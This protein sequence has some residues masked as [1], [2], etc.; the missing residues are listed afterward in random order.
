MGHPRAGGAGGRGR[1][2]GAPRGRRAARARARRRARPR[3]RAAGRA[4]RRDRP[5]DHRRE[6]QAD[7]VGPRRG[8]PGGLRRSAGPPRRPA[9]SPAR[10]QRLDTDPAATG[11][12]ALVTPRAARARCWASRR[13]TS[14]STWCA[15][16]VAPAIAVGAPIMLKPAPATPLSALVL[17]EILAET[18]PARP[19]CSR[20]CRSRTSARPRWSRTRACR[21]S[22]SPAPARSAAR[23]GDAVPRKHVT[24]ELGGNAAAVVCARLVDRGRPRLGRH[25]DRHLL[26]LPGR[27]DLHRRPAGDRGRVASTTGWPSWSSAKVEALV[28]GDPTDE[29][30][31]V[32]PLVSEDA[33][34]RVETWVRRGASP[35]GAKL[36]D[37][38]HARRRHRT[39]RPCST[40]VP[41]RRQ[42]LPRGGLR[43]GARRCPRS[44]RTPRRFAAVNDSDVRPAGRRVHAQPADRLP[45]PPR[46]SRSAA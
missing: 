44:T 18:G 13:S 45:G 37:R 34:E 27:P 35:P 7:Q 16:K 26:Q 8:R 24:L 19:A 32:G 43:A 9:A 31:D 21:W 10:L 4:R 12:L 5:A 17:G 30:T 39:R 36:L 2:R 20:C 14:R 46:R 22:R 11:R 33:A 23:S 38:R 6:R 42:G 3:R 41:G 29:A 28:T 25:P 1:R 40:D 15:H